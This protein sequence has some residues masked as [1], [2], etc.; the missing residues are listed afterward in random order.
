M[1]LHN[2][3]Y[4]ML[5]EGSAELG[6]CVKHTLCFVRCLGTQ[7]ENLRMDDVMMDWSEKGMKS[8]ATMFVEHET[9]H[10]DVC[11][12]KRNDLP[13]CGRNRMPQD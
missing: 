5:T 7:G 12:L 13:F 11:S 2:P 6:G 8:F 9:V 3:S 10:N 4:L 1:P